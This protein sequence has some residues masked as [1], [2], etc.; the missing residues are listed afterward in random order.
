[1]LMLIGRKVLGKLHRRILL[2]VL[3]RLS[4]AVVGRQLSRT[5]LRGHTAEHG[6]HF[7]AQTL[8]KQYEKEYVK[9]VIGVHERAGHRELLL[10]VQAALYVGRKQLEQNDQKHGQRAYQITDGKRHQAQS[11]L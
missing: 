8:A 4:K 7:L 10:E 11:E 6:E 9:A 3:E 2:R 5:R 1:M